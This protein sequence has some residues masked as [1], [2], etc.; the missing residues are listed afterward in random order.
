MDESAIYKKL[1][2]NF[3]P[4]YLKVDNESHL[5]DHHGQSPKN[6]NSHFSIVIKSEKF[7]NSTRIQGQREIY[8]VLK[9]ELNNG[10]H[11]LSIKILY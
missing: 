11:A 7:K 6:G 9:S 8:K 1:F 5:H 3:R 2:L 10:I 4:S